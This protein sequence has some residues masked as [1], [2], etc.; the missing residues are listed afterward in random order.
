[1]SGAL[2]LVVA[3]AF[4]TKDG[5]TWISYP[6]ISLPGAELGI[7]VFRDNGFATDRRNWLRRAEAAIREGTGL[8]IEG[9]VVPRQVHSGIVRAVGHGA[10]GEEVVCDGLVTSSRNL[11]VGVTV[12]DCV[13]LLAFDPVGQ[14]V[15]A[16]HCGWRGIAAGIVGSF[17]VAAGTEATRYLIGPSIGPCCYE[18]KD[19]MLSRFSE[20]DREACVEGRGG[21]LYFDIR[22][23]VVAGLMDSGAGPDQICVDNTCTSCQ[24]SLLSS[25]RAGGR[26]CGR[27]LAFAML[28]R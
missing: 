22:R 7:V 18:V 9:M 11:M 2:P 28:T 15:G 26:D 20:R 13:P 5:R 12:A 6:D 24:Q 16:A 23:A 3:P 14:T 1:M 4:E 25:Y 17:A 8:E 21:R 27:M 10:S 19:D